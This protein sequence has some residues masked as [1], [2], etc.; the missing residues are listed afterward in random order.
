MYI[1]IIA[2]LAGEK[3]ELS[4]R[5]EKIDHTIELLREL[6]GPSDPAEP[7][8]PE[9]RPV[10]LRKYNKRKVTPPNPALKAT[11]KLSKRKK[12]KYKGVSP[13][14]PNKSGKI[15][16]QAVHWDNKEKKCRTIGVYERELEAAAVYR[17][18]VGDTAKAADYRS[19]DKQQQGLDKKRQAD[20]TEQAENNPD[21]PS[22]KKKVAYYVCDHCHLET[23]T[24]PTSCIQCRGASFTGKTADADRV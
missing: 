17:D 9:A 18:H 10:A 11:G 12:S 23:Q 20:D 2:K 1:G 8:K 5:I 6:D 24:R 7:E 22:G 3:K 14:K 21:R 4:A 19:L 13:L 16:Y 15:R